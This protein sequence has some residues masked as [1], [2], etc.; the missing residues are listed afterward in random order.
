MKRG[1]PLLPLL[2]TIMRDRN[3]AR[4]TTAG[5]SV[6]RRAPRRTGLLQVRRVTAVHHRTNARASVRSNNNF[7]QR[8]SRHQIRNISTLRGGRLP[9]LANRDRIA[10]LL[11]VNVGIGTERVRQST[12]NGIHRLTIR[13]SF[14]RPI[15]KLRIRIAN[16]RH[17]FLLQNRNTG[18]VIRKRNINFRAR[19]V[20]LPL[21]RR[22]HNNFATTQQP[23]RRSSKTLLNNTTSVINGNRCLIVVSHLHVHRRNDNVLSSTNIRLLCNT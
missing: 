20:R 16:N 3:I 7:L 10:R 8:D 9:Q 11:N 15:E 2:R 4:L 14:I 21:R 19:D 6:P 1:V 18:V 23:Q 12:N 22:N 5:A 17:L 13:R